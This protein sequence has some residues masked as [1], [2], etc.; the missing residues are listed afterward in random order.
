MA[1][2]V[3]VGGFTYRIGK[4][5]ARR[6]FHVMRRMLPLFGALQD[7]QE[8]MVAGIAGAVSKL[9]DDEC[10]Y[11]LDNCLTIVDRRVGDTWVSLWNAR[12]KALQFQD[13]P[14]ADMLQIASAVLQDNL[15][16]FFSGLPSTSAAQ[17]TAV[18][19]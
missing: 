12:A 14:L 4:L 9:T 19:G 10:D 5:D 15:G 7:A 11:V 3:E 6:Q 2:E 1:T 18:Q 8:D 16:S 17:A 13:L